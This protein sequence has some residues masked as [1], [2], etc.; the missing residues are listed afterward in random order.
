M[1]RSIARI[2]DI[3]S[4]AFSM[5]EHEVEKAFKQVKKDKK[6]TILAVMNHDF[7]DM[8]DCHDNFISLLKKVSSS[9]PNIPFRYC[10]GVNAMRK[11]YGMEHK[12]PLKIDLSYDKPKKR[13][14]ITLDNKPFGKQP[15]CCFEIKSHRYFHEP[16]Y[17][18]GNKTW[19]YYINFNPDTIKNIG[20]A[21]NDDTGNTTVCKYNPDKNDLQT[22]TYSFEEKRK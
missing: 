19:A 6:S 8:R 14:L 1:R 13:F 3:K 2:L 5:T 21:C 18:V 17:K 22:K 7:R 20:V 15:Y 4:R 10:D 12:N 9:Y 11:Y 16:L